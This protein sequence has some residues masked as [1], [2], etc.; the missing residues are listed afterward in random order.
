MITVK[1]FLLNIRS[2]AENKDFLFG[3][4]DPDRA[5][6]AKRY[7]KES[8]GLLSLGAAYL[9]KKYVGEYSVDEKGKPHSERFFFNVSHSVDLVGIAICDCADTGLDIEKE[10]PESKDIIN[11]C[12]APEEMKAYVEGKKFLSLFVAKESLA[13]AE[14]TGI[15]GEIKKI[16]A[17]P[18]DGE[19]TYKGNIYY[20]HTVKKEGYYISVSIKNNDFVVITE[21]IERI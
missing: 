2:I 5:L 4:V 6:R 11:Y 17:L 20:R 16:P 9:I 12:L 15:F 13:K 7:V 14:G 18:I 21:E 3:Y 19:V 8:D 10:R 1:V